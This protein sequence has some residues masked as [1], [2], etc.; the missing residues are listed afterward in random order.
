MQ[1][2][3][4]R[5]FAYAG[6]YAGVRMA[7]GARLPTEGRL[8]RPTELAQLRRRDDALLHAHAPGLQRALAGSVRDE[9]REPVA[10][11]LRD[12][13]KHRRLSQ[14]RQVAD[15]GAAPTMGEASTWFYGTTWKDFLFAAAPGV[16]RLR[17]TDA[18]S[19]EAAAAMA[20]ALASGA[21]AA[22]A[23]DE[24][25]VP[26]VGIELQ[27]DRVVLRFHDEPRRYS[28]VEVV[29]SLL[30]ATTTLAEREAL[31]RAAIDQGPIGR[32]QFP[33][34][35]DLSVAV[36]INTTRI[37]RSERILQEGRP[38]TGAVFSL[39]GAQASH[40]GTLGTIGGAGS[41][42][43]DVRSGHYLPAVT[44][45]REAHE[46]TGRGLEGARCA[47]RHLAVQND[48]GFMLFEVVEDFDV[49]L[50]DVID[51][52]ALDRGEIAEMLFM[53]LSDPDSAV[54]FACL[55]G[56]SSLGATPWAALGIDA[57]LATHLAPERYEQARASLATRAGMRAAFAEVARRNPGA[58]EPLRAQP[59]LRPTIDRA[60]TTLDQAIAR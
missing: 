4:W 8:I 29:R 36:G 40:A 14:L 1:T 12:Y 56:I 48:G 44:A 18:I 10:Q 7:T 20:A 41:W 31:A 9:L 32:L 47:S 55:P 19:Q 22:V 46:E 27:P 34:I 49:L 5:T 15:G 37:H 23:Q 35:V 51:L 43:R 39:R 11:R 58:L 42:D 57:V 59:A 28:D 30:D 26:V 13:A 25:M 3:T 54:A 21:L 33:G 17:A 50:E 24:R 2:T 52:D 16:Q 6:S 38:C 53:P 45:T 60:L